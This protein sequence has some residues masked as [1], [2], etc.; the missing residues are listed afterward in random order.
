MKMFQA[1]DATVTGSW[2]IKIAYDFDNPDNEEDVAHVTAPTW[3][4]GRYE[5]QGFASHMSLRFYNNTA[6]AA[7]VSNAAIHYNMANDS[8]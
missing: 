3:N 8:D 1:I 2:D 5:L 7:V 6:E 4:K